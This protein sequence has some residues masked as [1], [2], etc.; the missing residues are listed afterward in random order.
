MSVRH[1]TIH[2]L[3]WTAE[4][5]KSFHLPIRGQILIA[6]QE[7]LCL[8]VVGVVEHLTGDNFKRGREMAGDAMFHSGLIH[9]ILRGHHCQGTVTSSIALIR[10]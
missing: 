10:T 1:S 8:P 9:K 5:F 4:F 7:S 6:P 3:P 2:L